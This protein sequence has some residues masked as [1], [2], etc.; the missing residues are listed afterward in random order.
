MYDHLK[1]ISVH[2]LEKPEENGKYIL[3]MEAEID[4]N[5]FSLVFGS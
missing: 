5:E 2:K 4:M 3:E 1:G